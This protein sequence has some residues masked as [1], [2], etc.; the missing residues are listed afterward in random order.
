MKELT[1]K[2]V[3]DAI[4]LPGIEGTSLKIFVREPTKKEIHRLR[5]TAQP[6]NW[7]AA[8]DGMIA[9]FGY[10]SLESI[11]ESYGIDPNSIP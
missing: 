8:P 5:A 4:N 10:D 6:T 2:S 7:V 9:P 1:A 3:E 11:S